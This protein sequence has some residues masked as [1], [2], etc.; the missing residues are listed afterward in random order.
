MKNLTDTHAHLFYPDYEEELDS[1]IE[2]AI[3]AGVESILVPATDLASSAKVVELTKKYEIIYGSVGVHPLDSKEWLKEW[4]PLLEQTVLA[5][6][7][8]IV[9]IGE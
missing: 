8:K 3:S 4:I 5:N 9:A 6:K 1:I 7:E 2:R